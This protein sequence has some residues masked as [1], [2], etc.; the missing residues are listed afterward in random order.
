MT[1][2]LHPYVLEDPHGVQT[3]TWNFFRQNRN[4]FD[5]MGWGVMHVLCEYSE[6]KDGN[7]PYEQGFKRAWEWGHTFV[8]VEQDLVPSVGAV[9]KLVEC[10]QPLCAQD[11]ML[12]L[13]IFC[14]PAMVQLKDGPV[15][16]CMSHRRGFDQ[17]FSMHRKVV[18]KKAR[19][20]RQLRLGKEQ[21]SDLGGFGLTKFSDSV[22]RDMPAAWKV[23]GWWDLDS[24]VGEYLLDH[25][26]TWHI[27]QPPVRH[28]H[29]DPH[30]RI[31]ERSNVKAPF[32]ERADLERQG[33]ADYLRSV[34]ATLGIQDKPMERAFRSWELSHKRDICTDEKPSR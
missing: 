4:R 9:Q 33:M 5:E 18:N 21:G 17:T 27:H 23:G 12:T 22:L 14:V 30:R 7:S 10:R 19:T 24:R 13:G 32:V 31:A 20:Y 6:E 16:T 2:L 8:T 15:W 1:L 26:Y 3:Q 11:Y 34:D 29:I 25:G 28:N